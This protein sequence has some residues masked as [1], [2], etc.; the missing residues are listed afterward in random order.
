[1]NIHFVL[2]LFLAV[3]AVFAIVTYIRVAN[4]PA[5]KQKPDQVVTREPGNRLLGAPQPISPEAHKDLV[6][7]LLGQ[8]AYQRKADA[9]QVK[10]GE[11]VD[12]DTVLGTMGWERWKDFPAANI[13]T[14]IDKFHL[15]VEVW[16]NP[17]VGAVA[18]AFGGTVFC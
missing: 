11:C 9:D 2:Y 15:R 18:V 17:S 7:A 16:S 5:Y 4:S 13:Q 3:I 12:A 8:A 6:F 1:M 14:R 10:V